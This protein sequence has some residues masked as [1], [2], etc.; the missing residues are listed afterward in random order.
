ML[1]L[2]RIHAC[3]FAP[4]GPNLSWRL[5]Q[6]NLARQTCSV[7]LSECRKN[8]HHIARANI[9]SGSLISG[10]CSDLGACGMRMYLFLGHP[11]PIISQH[12][13]RPTTS[14]TVLWGCWGR[15]KFRVSQTD[16]FRILVIVFLP[17]HMQTESNELSLV[18]SL[19]I[20]FPFQVFPLLKL[21]SMLLLP[22]SAWLWMAFRRSN[23]GGTCGQCGRTSLREPVCLA[24]LWLGLAEHLALNNWT[25]HPKQRYPDILLQFPGLWAVSLVLS[26]CTPFW[27]S[28]FRSPFSWS[29]KHELFRWKINTWDPFQQ[30]RMNSRDTDLNS[31]RSIS[32]HF[33]KSARTGFVYCTLVWGELL[34]FDWPLAPSRRHGN[35]DW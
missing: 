13:A 31:T 10:E 16:F 1:A 28:C 4:A 34:S 29:K 6:R 5:L 3:C 20:D 33:K 32:R 35:L 18:P 17:W 14:Y 7:R 26:W 19:F 12:A 27:M 8:R 2:I 9:G 11:S 21:W 24:R 30:A 15:K 23:V 22:R 25:A